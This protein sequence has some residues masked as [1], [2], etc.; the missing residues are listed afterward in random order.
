MGCGCIPP[1]PD[2]DLPPPP[3][4]TLIWD[5]LSDEPITEFVKLNYGQCEFNPMY[6]VLKGN[7][8]F[9]SLV[10]CVLFIVTAIGFLV[11]A[12]VYRRRRNSQK[13][14]PSSSLNST[15]KTNS[16]S[17]E[18]VVTSGQWPYGSTGHKVVSPQLLHSPTFYQP[19]AIVAQQNAQ[20]ALIRP[21][22]IHAGCGHSNS[23]GASRAY[24]NSLGAGCGSGN[25]SGAGFQGQ[26][27]SYGDG[28]GLGAGCGSGNSMGAGCG[29]Q[30]G[31][32]ASCGSQNRQR[33]ANLPINLHNLPQFS[34]SHQTFAQ[35][36][37]N[38]HAFQT[39]PYNYSNSC[40]MHSS[41][42]Y[43]TLSSQPPHYEEIMSEA[44]HYA[45]N[46]IHDPQRA[47]ERRPPPQ[48]RPP[49]PPTDDTEYH[50]PPT[51]NVNQ[52]NNNLVMG[53]QDRYGN[54]TTYMDGTTYPVPAPRQ[55]QN[56]TNSTISDDNSEL[57]TYL[58]QGEQCGV[59][60]SDLLGTV[61]TDLLQGTV[62]NDLLQHSD[63][64]G[65]ESGYGTGEKRLAGPSTSYPRSPIQSSPPNRVVTVTQK[66]TKQNMTYV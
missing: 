53:K 34:Q 56:T 4:P 37:N 21:M 12:M 2:F 5:L 46:P 10:L 40:C 57:D 28:N 41:N 64:K 18:T 59:A 52:L 6:N 63:P 54:S 22:P 16:G 42:G 55:C 7:E 13:R 60:T 50:V 49:P 48:C 39:L 31:P 35:L 17:A 45:A 20:G 11:G 30:N 65:R 38:Y 47:V 33:N 51:V 36:P 1:P 44:P 43:C 23:L 24:S 32:G 58:N 27:R 9:V 66:P 3:N 25:G 19:Q 8:V 15:S 26:N 29:S 14:C 62:P 61:P